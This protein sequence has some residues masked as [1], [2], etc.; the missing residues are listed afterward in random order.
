VIFR[1]Y[2]LDFAFATLL[3][4]ATYLLVRMV[5]R[6]EVL[7]RDGW[8]KRRWERASDYPLFYIY[9]LIVLV[10]FMVASAIL[11]YSNMGGHLALR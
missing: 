4:W 8:L 5:I 1:D 2:L 9:G 6:R 3:G 11:V 7:I 10:L